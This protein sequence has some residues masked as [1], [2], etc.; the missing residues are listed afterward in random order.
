MISVRS[1]VQ[2]LPGPPD[3]TGGVAQWE[4]TCFASRGST[5]RIRSPPP[6]MSEAIQRT[7]PASGL[8]MANARGKTRIG[9]FRIPGNGLGDEATASG[10]P[11]FFDMVKR[12]CD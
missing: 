5:V 12:E 3:R 11:G 9:K 6:E 8:K 1:E 10:S 4:S 7:K 2:V